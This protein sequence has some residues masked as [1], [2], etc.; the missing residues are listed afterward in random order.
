MAGMSF[1]VKRTPPFDGQRGASGVLLPR[2]LRRQRP[3]LA[4]E[5]VRLAGGAAEAERAHPSR[6]A[7]AE[8]FVELARTRAIL[9]ALAGD[10]HDG[11]EKARR[12]GVAALRPGDQQHRAGR[13]GRLEREQE[14][15]ADL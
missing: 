4:A 7:A 11:G 15:A 12:P 5:P 13:M 8:R 2:L 6:A 9:R 1:S 3:A 14:P 10:E